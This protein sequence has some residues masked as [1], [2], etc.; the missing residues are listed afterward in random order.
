MNQIN[1][2]GSVADDCLSQNNFQFNQIKPIICWKIKGNVVFAL[3]QRGE[4]EKNK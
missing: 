3:W 2:E 4:K 1:R